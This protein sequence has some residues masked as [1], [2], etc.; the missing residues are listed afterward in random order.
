MTGTKRDQV[1]KAWRVTV[2]RRWWWQRNSPIKTSSRCEWC[3]RS[4]WCSK[5]SIYRWILDDLKQF[6]LIILRSSKLFVS[7]QI[8]AD[9]WWQVSITSVCLLLEN[10]QPPPVAC[11]LHSFSWR[12]SFYTR[13]NHCKCFILHLLT[14]TIN[15]NGG[16]SL[17]YWDVAVVDKQTVDLQSLSLTAMVFDDSNGRLRII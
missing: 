7:W 1:D 10:Y 15:N 11:R 8:Q 14:V 16:V 4:W 6:S 9:D 17:R 12:L 13:F 5:L 3:G 2:R